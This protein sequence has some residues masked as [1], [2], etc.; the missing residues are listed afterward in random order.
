[1]EARL[2]E[3]KEDY[4]K[5]REQMKGSNDFVPKPRR[6]VRVTTSVKQI[7]CDC[8]SSVSCVIWINACI[9]ICSEPVHHQL[10]RYQLVRY[11]LVRY[12]PRL[13]DSAH[14]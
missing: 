12:Q 10:V 9:A 14:S 1:M 3:A 4:V 8:V 6:L 13:A 11:Q 2:E 7:C 5:Q